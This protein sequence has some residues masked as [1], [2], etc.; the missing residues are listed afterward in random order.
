MG[1][2][3]ING[4]TIQACLDALFYVCT[5]TMYL[6]IVFVNLNLCSEFAET[7][8]FTIEMDMLDMM[9]KWMDM[10]GPNSLVNR[11][12]WIWIPSIFC[13]DMDGSG[14]TYFLLKDMDGY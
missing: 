11:Y 2:L 4:F 9:L 5:K 8:A 12:G 7:L 10:D 3:N 14:F 6:L 1:H 13:M